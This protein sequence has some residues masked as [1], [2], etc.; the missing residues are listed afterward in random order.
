M[1]T[2]SNHKIYLDQGNLD[3]KFYYDYIRQHIQERFQI[4]CDKIFI[5]EENF[6]EYYSTSINNNMLCYYNELWFLDIGDV[7]KENGIYLPVYIENINT[8]SYYSLA[9]SYIN[10]DDEQIYKTYDELINMCPKTIQSQVSNIL[11]NKV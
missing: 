9:K 3:K 10:T 4:I 2:S 11:H 5:N 8:S 7:F 6:I 1:S